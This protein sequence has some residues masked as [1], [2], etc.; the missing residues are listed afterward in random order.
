MA[1]GTASASITKELE[2]SDTGTSPPF[3]PQQENNRAPHTI[4]MK[5]AGKLLLR[6]FIFIVFTVID[7]YFLMPHGSNANHKVPY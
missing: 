7:N 5:K 4:E 1:S 2:S 3:F 6:E